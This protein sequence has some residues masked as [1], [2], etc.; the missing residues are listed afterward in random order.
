MKGMIRA[1]HLL[2]MLGLA[3]AAPAGA[4]TIG[5]VEDFSVDASGW[6]NSGGP[7]TWGARGGPGGGLYGSFNGPS[8]NNPGTIQFRTS[9]AAASGG[10]FAGSWLSPGVSVLSAEGLDD[11]P[12]PGEGFFRIT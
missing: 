4:A 11:A 9:S 6:T 12:A 3:L 10:N 5:Y 7:L 1:V 8:I 2:G